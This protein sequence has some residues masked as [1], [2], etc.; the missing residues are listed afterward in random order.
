MDLEDKEVYDELDF[1][2]IK[3]IKE[4]GSD[5]ARLA[6]IYHGYDSY[7]VIYVTYEASY[8][9]TVLKNMKSSIRKSI[10]EDSRSVN[11]RV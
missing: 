5:C 9:D 3:A 7:F 10:Y 2:I 8:K 6:Y 1:T 4:D 11:S